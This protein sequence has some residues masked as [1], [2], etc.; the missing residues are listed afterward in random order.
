MDLLLAFFATL[1]LIPILIRSTIDPDFNRN[2]L[3]IR[4]VPKAGGVAIFLGILA[5]LVVS[6]YAEAHPGFTLLVVVAAGLGLL[7]DMQKISADS[8]F[9]KQLIL[10]I[11]T[12][13][14]GY[15][16]SFLGFTI[17]SILTVLWIVGCL[18]IFK[19]ID[20]MDGLAVGV[21]F[22]SS[23]A[24]LILLIPGF[25]GALLPLAGSLL[26]FLLFNLKPA[27][28]NL[29]NSGTMLLGYYLA[30]MGIK[31][32]SSANSKLLGMLAVILIFA[33]PIFDAFLN[34]I[35]RKR[36]HSCQIIPDQLGV[37]YFDS[38]LR[39]YG[40]SSVLAAIG[41]LTYESFSFNEGILVFLCVLVALV[42]AIKRYDL[43]A[44]SKYEQGGEKVINLNF[45]RK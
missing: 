22:I 37:G 21:A 23:I 45:R 44:E 1:V 39:I 26:A 29:G 38:I 2:R 10:A 15:R 14:I 25:S 41:I 13:T 3:R 42:F 33:Y 32:Q 6:G 19:S 43:L 30:L 24:V 20:R 36:N 18:K 16:F 28:I 5:G 7:E 34:I 8:V 27:S 31:V 9:N 4:A 12:L 40:L 11:C 17:D 35:R